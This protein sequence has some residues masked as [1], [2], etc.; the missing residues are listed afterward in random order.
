[1]RNLYIIILTFFVNSVFAQQ[2][3]KVHNSGN[4]IFATKTSAVDSIKL[5]STYGKFNIS[6]SSSSLNI[7][8]AIID[9][10]TF[11]TTSVILDKIYIIYNVTDNATI[12][13]PYATSGVAI[14]AIGGVVSVTAISGIA[15]LEYNILGSSLT[16]S[17]TMKTD[18][19]VNLVLNNLTLMNPTGAAFSISGGKTSNI[20]LTNNTTNTLSDGAEST[21]NGTITTDGPIVIQNNGALIIQGVKKHGINTSSTINILGGTTTISAAASDGMHSEGYLMTGGTATINSLADGI[22]A[23]N[24]AITISGGTINVTSSTDDTKAIKTGNNL[25]TIDGGSINLTV[26]GAQSKAISSKGNITIN[27]G[28]IAATISGASVLTA[29]GSGFDASHSSAINTDSILT[30][31]G[32]SFNIQSLTNADGGKGFS[33]NY[34]INITGGNININ[35]AGKGGSYKNSTGVA[36]SYTTAGISSKRNVHISGG[37]LAITNSGINGKG[38]SVDSN[39]IISGLSQLTIN[40]TGNAGK[41]IKTDGDII[42]NGG[43]TTVT[44]SGST[45]LV[46]SGSGNDPSYPTGLKSMGEVSI[47]DGTLKIVGTSTATGAK[48]ISADKGIIVNGGNTTVTT[49]GNGAVYTNSL[50]KADS[51]SAAAISSDKSI[52]INNGTVNT[53]SS[54]TGGKGL[55][56][57]GTIT[58]GTANT[59]PIL[60]ITTTGARF[61]VSGTDYCHPK[62]IVSVGPVKIINGT[63]TLNS[64]D[65]GIHSDTSV[66]ISG[67]NNIVN[68]I[69]TTNGVG[70]GV[71]APLINF[72]GGVTNIT[73][74][75]DGINATYGTVSGGTESND[76]SNLNISGGVQIVAG[77]DAIDSNGNITITGGITIVCGV[78]NQP[79]EGLDFNGAFNMNGGM[80]ISA[81]SNSNMTKNFSTTSSQYSMFLKSSA[82]L[83]ATSMLHIKSTA[84]TEMVTF[85]PKNGVNYFH[86]SNPSITPNT[87]YQI[88]FGGTYTG[89]SFEGGA[90]G[91]GLY[92][93]G[94][95]STTGATL[96]STFTTSATSKINTVTF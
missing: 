72:T 77:K 63:N 45:V 85:K 53:T 22:D 90:S 28:S 96:K 10:L 94:S 82:Q 66:T 88:Y 86:F 49:A 16:G 62:T 8:K 37:N 83:A 87:S 46:V 27:S 57:D 68:A 59:T 38:I 81:G 35:T 51:Y 19:D 84:G 33:A 41:C 76:N 5:D 93:D 2:T 4:I 15:N 30:I 17:L 39:V 95:Y 70:E 79:E 25:I 91:W 9:S 23:G 20:L 13:N 61:V 7:Q 47:N 18:K 60:N 56:S 14:S 32:G 75:N 31:N 50:G 89:G 24:G 58:I 29:V 92:K 1:M 52:V 54:G 40:N 11:S 21:K 64:T 3:L 73:A 69:S 44:N 34:D 26:T 43:S 12:I 65:D 42:I 74:S 71:E 55:K 80:I 48:G 6:N 36:D 78:T 67:G